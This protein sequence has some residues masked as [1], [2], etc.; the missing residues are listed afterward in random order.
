MVFQEYKTALHFMHPRDPTKSKLTP[1][2]YRDSLKVYGTKGT[3]TSMWCWT[4]VGKQSQTEEL[5]SSTMMRRVRTVPWVGEITVTGSEFFPGKRETKNV[6]IR[7][8]W[9]SLKEKVRILRK[10]SSNHHRRWQNWETRRASSQGPIRV[11]QH[12]CSCLARVFPLYPFSLL[13]SLG[14]RSNVCFTHS[15]LVLTFSCNSTNLWQKMHI[16]LED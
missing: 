15:L 12:N 13:I 9:K 6:Q 3:R 10:S 8:T 11:A 1:I 2:L 4:G 16:S 7:T 5:L 14:T